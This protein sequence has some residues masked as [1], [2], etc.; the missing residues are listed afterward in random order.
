MQSNNKH[1]WSYV[2]INEVRF[3][4]QNAYV[5]E[6]VL[7]YEKKNGVTNLKELVLVARA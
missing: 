3:L 6:L 2:N 5:E 4:K 1:V 7:L